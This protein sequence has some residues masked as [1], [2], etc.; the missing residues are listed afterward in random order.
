M[1]I[2]L[3]DLSGQVALVTGSTSGLGREIA[4]GLAEAGATVV[5]NGRNPERLDEAVAA[6]RGAGHA[7]YASR[8]DVTSADQIE[9]AVASIEAEIGPIGIL[10]KHC[11]HLQNA[12]R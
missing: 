7:A 3:F 2:S 11:R 4:R 10:F 9:R 12:R 1:S 6:L 8:F 5:V